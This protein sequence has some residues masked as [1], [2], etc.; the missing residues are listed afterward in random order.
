[1]NHSKRA[2]AGRHWRSVCFSRSH[3]GCYRLIR[4]AELL[5]DAANKRDRHSH[6]T[7]RAAIDDL[8]PC[9][10]RFAGHDRGRT[11]D[12]AG[13][14]ARADAFYA[15]AAIWN[16]ACRPTG[17]RHGH[18]NFYC[19]GLT[20][21]RIASPSRR[22]RR[23]HHRPPLRINHGSTNHKRTMK[24]GAAQRSEIKKNYKRRSKEADRT[25]PSIFSLTALILGTKVFWN[26]SEQDQAA[27]GR[28]KP[29]VQMVR[30][31][32]PAPSM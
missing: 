12:W 19:N 29:M 22:P 18:G 7:G 28:Q 11:H 1:V 6:R 3:S 25:L 2:T 13:W 30:T 16:P 8:P 10:E 24:I 31:G 20:R 32:P 17:Y 21:W 15:V 9:A 5:R 23:S 4:V 26:S 14:F 27:I